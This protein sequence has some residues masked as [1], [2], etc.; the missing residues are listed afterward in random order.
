[1]AD[2]YRVTCKECG[3][4]DLKTNPDQKSY[5]SVCGGM[6]EKEVKEEVYKFRVVLVVDGSIEGKKVS[7]VTSRKVA[8]ASQDEA[9]RKAQKK[10]KD[11]PDYNTDISVNKRRFPDGEYLDNWSYRPSSVR[12]VAVE[13]EDEAT[14]TVKW[15]NYR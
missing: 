2:G 3:E 11:N 7:G 4:E 1:M 12:V 5:C 9:R 10:F 13:P 14:K 8:A 15:R 6:T